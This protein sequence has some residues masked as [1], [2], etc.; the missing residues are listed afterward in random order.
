MKP[1]VS[2]PLL[3]DAPRGRR[4]R[5]ISRKIGYNEPRFVS[6]SFDEPEGVAERGEFAQIR[7]RETKP[8]INFHRDR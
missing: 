2:G 1:K 7:R 6:R 4:P 3:A 5:E 8:N